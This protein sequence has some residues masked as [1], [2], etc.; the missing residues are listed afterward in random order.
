MNINAFP[1]EAAYFGERDGDTIAY[2]ISIDELGYIYISGTSNAVRNGATG[3]APTPSNEQIWIYART[4][5][6][7][8][9]E[10][11]FEQTSN[12]YTGVTEFLSKRFTQPLKSTNNDGVIFTY[13]FLTTEASTSGGYAV[14]S[15]AINEDTFALS[16]FVSSGGS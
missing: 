13:D 5:W 15:L 10:A 7:L 1:D 8:H 2:A 4:H 12:V 3:T 14:S 9:Y 6:E 11:T 16:L